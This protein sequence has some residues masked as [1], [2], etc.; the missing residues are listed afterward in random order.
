M[1]PG[2]ATS[3]RTENGAVR[4]ENIQG[5]IT[6]AST[7]GPVVGRGLSGSVDA[8]TVN[9][10]IEIGLTA[11]MRRLEDHHRQ[12]AGDADLSHRGRR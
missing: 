4:L 12:R 3:F 7:N 5:R 10:G 2:L 9:G 11:L 8:S 6:V 1:P